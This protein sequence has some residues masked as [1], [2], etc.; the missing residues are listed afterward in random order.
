MEV[1]VSLSANKTRAINQSGKDDRKISSLFLEGLMVCAGLALGLTTVRAQSTG[2]LQGKVIDPD[3]AAVAGVEI[4]VISSG[5]GLRRESA[6]DDSG[7]Y[8]IVSLPVGDYR[9]DARAPGF[10]TQIVE[11]VRLEVGRS[12]TQDFQLKI[13]DVAEEVVVRSNSNIIE[14]ATVSVGHM[15]DRRTVQDIPLNGRHFIDLGLLAAGSVT[16]RQNG[17][18]SAPS[19][20][21]GM[22]GMN[23]AGNRE[24][25]VNFQING[26]NF[27][28]LINNI[29][30]MLPPINSIQEFRIDNS[31][32]QRRVRAQLG[33]RRQRR[34]RVRAPTETT[35]S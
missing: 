30:T 28:D 1:R 25:N 31:T 26:I 21:Q 6:T 5:I 18:L 7:R 2:T 14:L 4:T 22:Q 19:R 13:G 9:I 32:L 17:S 16:P 23:T 15:V 35:A 33:L 24:D 8:Q 27:N 34:K 11:T 29:I 3:G 12:I 10:Q 20:G